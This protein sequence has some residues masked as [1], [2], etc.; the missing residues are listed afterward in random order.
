MPNDARIGYGTTLSFQPPSTT[1]E[2]ITGIV[3]ERSWSISGVGRE[4]IDASHAASPNRFRQMIAGMGTPGT[5][6]CSCLFDGETMTKALYEALIASDETWDVV[7][8]WTKFDSSNSTG[9]IITTKG[10]VTN[11]T[12]SGEYDNVI[13]ISFEI[14]LTGKPVY[15]TET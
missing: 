11:S 4:A 2:H 9:A 1:T 5:M 13:E 3:N 15:T 6:S 14:Q 12:I 7:L 8:T 10:F